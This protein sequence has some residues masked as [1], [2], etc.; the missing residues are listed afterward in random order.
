LAGVFL[1]VFLAAVFLAIAAPSGDEDPTR[2]VS[3]PGSGNSRTGRAATGHRHADTRGT[4][5]PA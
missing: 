3:A 5:L 1:A 4:I 2:S